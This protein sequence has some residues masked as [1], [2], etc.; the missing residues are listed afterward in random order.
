MNCWLKFK[1]I[2]K[3]THR[4]KKKKETSKSKG[5]KT[6]LLRFQSASK[7]HSKKHPTIQ[8]APKTSKCHHARAGREPSQVLRGMCCCTLPPA[9][10]TMSEEAGRDATAPLF[11]T[12]IYKEL[13]K[14]LALDIIALGRLRTFLEETRHCPGDLEKI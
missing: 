5:S 11:W 4:E 9:T 13:L 14:S 12:S 3:S 7:S 6:V 2:F 8:N 1:N 10:P